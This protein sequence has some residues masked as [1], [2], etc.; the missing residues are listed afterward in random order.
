[1]N[2]NILNAIKTSRDGT[3]F[4]G[5]PHVYIRGSSVKY[6]CIKDKV[7]SKVK[8]NVEEQKRNR[9]YRGRNRGRGRIG[10][11]RGRGGRGGRGRRGR[12]RGNRN[13]GGNNRGR[14]K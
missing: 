5:I 14:G 9:S 1:M 11:G 12:G 6:L 3:N 7:M 2:L 10:R 8:E 13:R 4:L